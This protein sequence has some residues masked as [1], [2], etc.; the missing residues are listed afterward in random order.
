MKRFV[1]VRGN[2]FEDVNEISTE[3]SSEV[4]ARVIQLYPLFPRHLRHGL[5]ECVRE[6]CDGGG[7]V[8]CVC[9]LCALQSVFAL[10]LIKK[11]RLCFIALASL[12][13]AEG[14]KNAYS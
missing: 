5:R 8:S 14:E 6:G 9:C 12:G 10:R 13:R 7:D 1:C 11:T 2:F 3:E 4:F